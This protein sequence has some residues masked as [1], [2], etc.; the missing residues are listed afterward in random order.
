MGKNKSENLGVEN[1]KIL[2]KKITKEKLLIMIY[3]ETSNAELSEK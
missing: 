3:N 1:A 2:P